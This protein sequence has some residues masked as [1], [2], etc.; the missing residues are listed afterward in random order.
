MSYGDL[1]LPIALSTVAVWLLSAVLHMVLKHHRADYRKLPQEDALGAVI[2]KDAPA[3][4]VYFMPYAMDPAQM[5]DPA[6]Q[7]KFQEGPVATLTVMRNGA[8]NLGRHLVQWLAFC[9]LV[10]FVAG[11]VAKNTLLPASGGLTAM[12]IT[13][14]VALVGYAFGYFQDSI[15]KGIP[16]SNSLRAIADGII[17]ALATGLIFRVLWPTP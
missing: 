11:Y 14:T 8:P 1:W 12:R 2:R 3:P 6:I 15:W 5:K 17:Y 9:L 16:W 7:K 13:G 10:S 4:G